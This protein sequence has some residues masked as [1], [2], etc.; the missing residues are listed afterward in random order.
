MPITKGLLNITSDAK[1]E[2]EII[3]LKKKIVSLSFR[4]RNEAE[5]KENI[6]HFIIIFILYKASNMQLKI[7]SIV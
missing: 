2:N 7:F 3:F 4:K 1:K 5:I 6:V